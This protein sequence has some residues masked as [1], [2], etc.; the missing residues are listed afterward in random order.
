[1][2]SKDGKYFFK[3][4][5]K[6]I[7]VL[8]NF[9]KH[10]KKNF[11][12]LQTRSLLLAISGGLDSVVM[13]HLMRKYAKNCTIAHCN[14]Q[15]REAASDLDALF[16]KNLGASMKIPVV[17]VNFDT[18]AYADEYNVSIQMAAR[19]LRYD[20]FKRLKKNAT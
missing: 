1:L 7:P 16:V 14:F 17:S 13:L 18:E 8:E 9:D 4:S 15:L 5:N 10:L 3:K 2:N 12:L 6:P 19:K 11:P 20:W